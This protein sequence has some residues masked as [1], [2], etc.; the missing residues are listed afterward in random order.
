M[1]CPLHQPRTIKIRGA[2]V[3]R[4]CRYNDPGD[5]AACRG[6]GVSECD[7][8][9]KG[10]HIAASDGNSANGAGLSVSF[11]EH[12][13]VAGSILDTSLTIIHSD[14]GQQQTVVRC[15]NSLTVSKRDCHMRLSGPSNVRVVRIDSEIVKGAAV[16]SVG[17]AIENERI[18]L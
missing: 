11:A 2:V 9:A 16:A 5:C 4:G 3:I 6:N 15:L 14:C 13:G 18:A 17:V 7:G 1:G 10:I 8:V 12:E